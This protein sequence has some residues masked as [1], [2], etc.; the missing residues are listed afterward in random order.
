MTALA[1]R[2]AELDRIQ[3]QINLRLQFHQDR[4]LEHIA[5]HENKEKYHEY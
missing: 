2:G 5:S 4:L 3:Q 1:P